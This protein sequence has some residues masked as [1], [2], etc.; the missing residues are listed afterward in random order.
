MNHSDPYIFSRGSLKLT[1]DLLRKVNPSLALTVRNI[2]SLSPLPKLEGD[3]NNEITDCF[4][5]D[6]DSFQVRAV[7]EGLI[8][9]SHLAAH[10]DSGMKVV[11]EA[12]LE[13]WLAL[14]HAMVDELAED[15][16]P[17]F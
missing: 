16:K 3:V 2:N 15:Q 17:S 1:Y 11:A 9:R 5:I 6:L 10:D 8:K 4:L 13:D 14:A 7:V 12:L